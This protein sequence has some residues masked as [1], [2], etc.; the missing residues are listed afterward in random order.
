MRIPLHH[1]LAA[2]YEYPAQNKMNKTIGML[3]MTLFLPV[4]LCG[5]E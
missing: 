1:G 4:M 2:G 3:L 5:C